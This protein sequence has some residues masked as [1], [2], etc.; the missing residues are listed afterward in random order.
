[1]D[2][3]YYKLISVCVFRIDKTLQDIEKKNDVNLRWKESDRVF[4]ET[5]QRIFTKKQKVE[6]NQ[7]RSK[8]VERWFLL[9][10]KSKYSG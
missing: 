1:M 2:L 5:R 3:S 10:L 6:L 7:I 8:V 4:Q 9:S